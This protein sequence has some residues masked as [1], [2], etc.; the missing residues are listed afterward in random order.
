MNKELLNTLIKKAAN[1]EQ[2][3][4][5]VDNFAFHAQDFEKFAELIVSECAKIAD[6]NY[7]NGFCPVGGDI[8]K[9]FGVN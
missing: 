4:I 1:L 9:H 7:N 3:T 5:Q 2:T 8:R 6:D